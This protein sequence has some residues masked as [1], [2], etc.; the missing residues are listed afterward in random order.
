MKQIPKVNLSTSFAT[1]P[2]RSLS[3]ISMIGCLAGV[4]AAN[5]PYNLF[6]QASRCPSLIAALAFALS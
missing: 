4:D 2:H 5:N 6:H 1:M 3:R